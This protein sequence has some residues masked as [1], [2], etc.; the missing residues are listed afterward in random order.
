MGFGAKPQIFFLKKW[1]M[2][3]IKVIGVPAMGGDALNE[4]LNRF[5]RGHKVIKVTQELV[6][7][8][9]GAYWAFCIHYIDGSAAAADDRK[10]RKDYRELL[11]PEHFERF[12]KLRTVR[13]ALADEDSVP[14]FSILTD[15]Q[16]AAVAQLPEL[17][18]AAMR[19]VKGVG[20]KK[21]ERYGARFL[22]ALANEKSQ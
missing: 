1:D 22:Q 9:S 2:M 13:K 17:T 10:E 5:L 6:S 19:Q 11:S 20:D 16:M 7:S 3:L 12:A 15:E 8:D 21:V 18:E 14:A 4:D